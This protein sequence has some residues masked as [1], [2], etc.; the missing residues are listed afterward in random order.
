MHMGLYDDSSTY[1]N[2]LL[3]DTGAVLV[4][5]GYPYNTFT[6]VAL[7]TSVV[8]LAYLG[9]GASVDINSKTGETSG[10]RIQKV[11]SYGAMPNPFPA[12]GSGS[13]KVMRAK[14]AHS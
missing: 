1:P 6:E 14:I 11:Q 4:A 13:T 9:D 3:G 10:H 12:A 5:T 8:W 7:T 2:A